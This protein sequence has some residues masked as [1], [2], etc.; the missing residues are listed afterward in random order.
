[1][2]PIPFHV[3]TIE[4]A[5]IE[6]VLKTLRSGWVTTGPSARKFEQDFAEYLGGGVECVAVNSCTAAMHLAVEAAGL[7]AGDLAITT[8][9]TFTA[10]AEVLRYVGAAPLFVDIDSAT[11]RMEPAA[12]RA[13]IEALAPDERKRLKA[14]LPVHYGG[15][16]A[17]MEGFE[18]LAQEFDLALLDDAAHALPA[19]RQ[20]R[21]IGRWGTITSFSFYATKTLCTG[22]GG[23]AVSSDPRLAE[24]MRTMRL[25]GINR[26]VF[27]RYTSEQPAWYYE[28]VAPGF[29]YNLSDVAA[30]MGV[31]QLPRIDSFRER[32][33]SIAQRYDAAFS[34]HPALEV[35]PQP[36][37]GDLHAWHLYPL[38]IHGGRENRDHVIDRLARARIG[39]SV[40]FIPLHLQPYWRDRY[41]L[42][43]DDYPASTQLFSEEI[44]LP[45]YPA[46]TTEQVDRV[47]AELG[48]AT[49]SG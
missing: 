44:S 28:V 23:M 42:S 24:R 1:M 43:P 2:E 25:H 7:G 21:W 32:R 20:G 4:E 34:E 6:A 27:D 19:Q 10:T 41:R 9:F 15:N 13:R 17:A 29:K 16:P 38:R 12:V 48:T 35:P 22:E 11:L 36:D 18:E 3:P 31:T 39:T 8:P 26:D 37:G 5:D 49:R 45:I 14:I 46:M 33:E 30:A 47:I 40:H